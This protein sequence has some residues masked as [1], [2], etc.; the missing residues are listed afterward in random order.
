MR[1]F[2]QKVTGVDPKTAPKHYEKF[3]VKNRKFLE[4][5]LKSDEKT[6]VF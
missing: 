3:A 4:K 6:D 5:C 2:Y 1:Q